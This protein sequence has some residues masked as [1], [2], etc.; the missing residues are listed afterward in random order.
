MKDRRNTTPEAREGRER[1]QEHI[2]RFRLT[3][4][5]YRILVGLARYHGTTIA[6]LINGALPLIIEKY[7]VLRALHVPPDARVAWRRSS[8]RRF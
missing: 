4:P 5:D 7:R 1:E 8:A 6:T 2:V 3:D